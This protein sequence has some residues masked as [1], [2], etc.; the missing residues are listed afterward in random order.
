MAD[1]WS[2]LGVQP[3][4][5]KAQIKAAFRKKAMAHHP[6]MHSTASE[7]VQK[8]HDAA[9]KALNEAYQA[10]MD[11]SHRYRQRSAGRGGFAQ[12]SHYYNASASSSGGAGGHYNPYSSYYGSGTGSRYSGWRQYRRR[13]GFGHAR[14]LPLFLE[15]GHADPLLLWLADFTG[16]FRSFAGISRAGAA[17]TTTLG[18]LLVGGVLLLEPLTGAM[19]ERNNSGKLFS[20]IEEDYKRR[21]QQQQQATLAAAVAAAQERV[22]QHATTAA[23]QEQPDA[24]MG[25]PKLFHASD[26]LLSLSCLN[27]VRALA[28]VWV[29]VVHCWTLWSVL[30]PYDVLRQL[31]NHSWLPWV[32]VQGAC[33]ADTFLVLSAVLATYHLLPVLEGSG[34]KGNGSAAKQH[35]SSC[36]QVVLKYWRRRALRILPAYAVANLLALVMFWPTRQ[37]PPLGSQARDVSYGRCPH[38]LWANVFFVTNRLSLPQTC[39]GQ[40]WTTSIVVHMYTAWPLLLCALRP[41]VPGFRARVAVALAAAVAAGTAW[42]F[43]SASQAKFHLPVGDRT[44]PEEEANLTRILETVYFPTLSRLAELAIGAALGLLLRSHTAISWV[45]RRPMLV[46]GTAFA[47]QGMY[48]ITVSGGNLHPPKDVPLLPPLAAKLV[49]TFLFYGSPFHACLVS[50]T[51]LALVLRSDPLHAAAARLLST[52]P[53]AAAATLSYSVYLLHEMVKIGLVT[54][55][56]GLLTAFLDN[57]PQAALAGLIAATLVASYAVGYLNWRLVERRFY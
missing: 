56:P 43:W 10:L 12:T 46:S 53:L 52:R 42:R 23:A 38:A 55:A 6:D 39:G 1:P 44:V 30:L 45:M 13:S 15:P 47:L 5:S 16:L 14:D 27:G 49:A 34:G 24:D 17:V 33:G 48:L 20:S 35:G 19:W 40:F 8:A 26:G 57:A 11:G 9:F 22:M 25:A 50:A 4:A 37:L 54:V 28:N 21:K 32:A 29:L 3:D 7:G 18:L 41:R 36:R 2:L 31:G 51:L